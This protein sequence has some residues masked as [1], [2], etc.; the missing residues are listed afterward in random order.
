MASAALIRLDR[1]C[2]V[3]CSH[4]SRRAVAALGVETLEPGFPA[5]RAGGE[6]DHYRPAT[7][8]D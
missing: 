7:Q 1:G 4:W 2:L 5:A 8:V 3:S 6:S